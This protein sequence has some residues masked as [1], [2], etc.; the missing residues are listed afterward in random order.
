MA[1]SL[2]NQGVRTPHKGGLGRCVHTFRRGLFVKFRKSPHRTEKALRHAQKPANPRSANPIG[3]ESTS[4]VPGED[5]PMANPPRAR[6]MTPE[7]PFPSLIETGKSYPK[8]GLFPAF[9]GGSTEVRRRRSHPP[10]PSPQKGPGG[11]HVKERWW[12]QRTGGVLDHTGTGW[13]WPTVRDRSLPR[14]RV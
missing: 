12:F 4:V 9:P 3:W 7:R 2:N 13:I 5:P 14:C 8:T 11:H 10:G 6:K 1:N